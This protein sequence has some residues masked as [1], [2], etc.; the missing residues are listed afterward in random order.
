LFPDTLTTISLD[1]PAVSVLGGSYANVDIDGTT[2]TITISGNGNSYIITGATTEY[3][4]N[5]TGNNNRVLLKGVSI[6]SGGTPFCLSGPSLNGSMYTT[7]VYLAPGTR[8]FLKTENAT[9]L[10]IIHGANLKLYGGEV[11]NVAEPVSA[12][13]DNGGGETYH[14]G[15]LTAV[16]TGSP[17]DLGAGIGAGSSLE[18]KSV[19]NGSSGSIYIS[20]GSR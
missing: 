20:G 10:Q 4:V 15:R 2:K 19:N 1:T 9:P 6:V 14:Y 3:G 16:Y 11:D 13:G 5:V 8:N 18:N 12:Y 17:M 7:E